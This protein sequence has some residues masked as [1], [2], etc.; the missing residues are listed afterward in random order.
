M[1]LEARYLFNGAS[2]LDKMLAAV[3]AYK[4][5]LAR[6]SR[7]ALAWA[8]L[9]DAYTYNAIFQM[10]GGSEEYQEAR[11]AAQHA[12]SLNP[13]LAE[14]HAALAGIYLAHDWDFDG[15]ERESRLAVSLSPGSSWSHHWMYHVHQVRGRL[16]AAD[17]ELGKALS[18]DPTA[19]ILLSDRAEF[20][21]YRDA[22]DDAIREYDQCLKFHPDQTGCAVYR[23]I[24]AL[25]KGDVAAAHRTMPQLGPFMPLLDPFEAF[26]VGDKERVRRGLQRLG[27]HRS[28]NEP[29]LPATLYVLLGDW[30]SADQWLERC[31]RARSPNMIFL[32]LV[33][34]LRS[35]DP[36]YQAWLDRMK[37]P[38]VTQ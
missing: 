6:D 16:Q 19:V 26:S 31:Y 11:E 33:K 24:A 38:R 4:K 27:E 10:G 14:A 9:A 29:L 35:D 21:L 2:S 37:L 28:M 20:T 22:W 5:V 1:F 8:G 13:A 25:R 23:T 17:D 12:I 3:E 30:N 32:H 7:Y 36:R 18:L 34:D 15:A